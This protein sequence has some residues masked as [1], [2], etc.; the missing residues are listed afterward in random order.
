MPNIITTFIINNMC[1]TQ[2]GYSENVFVS[3]V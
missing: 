1:T 3:L 2:S